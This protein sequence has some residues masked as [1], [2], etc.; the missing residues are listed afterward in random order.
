MMND[1]KAHQNGHL[2]AP[3]EVAKRKNSQ[4]K[5]GGGE[6]VTSTTTVMAMD[7]MPDVKVSHIIGKSQRVIVFDCER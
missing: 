1:G 2:S 4:G 6:M 5:G 3:L 7:E